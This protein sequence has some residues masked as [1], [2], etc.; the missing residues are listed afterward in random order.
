MTKRALWAATLALALATAPSAWAQFA[1]GNI[2][3]NVTDE[4]G[5]VLP[6]ATITMTGATIGARSTTAGSQ[7]DFRFL[8]LDPGS[9]KLSVA[10]TGFT[11]VNREVKVVTGTNVNLTFGLK[12]ATVEETVTVTAET[13]VVD[14]KKTGTS[15]TMSRD[16]LEKVPQAR[17]PWAVLRAVPGVLLDRVNIAGNESG[18]QAGFVAKGASDNNTIWNMDGVAITDMSAIGASPTYFDYDAFEEI[19]VS[20]GG[21]DI[22]AATGGISLN[23]VTK[24]GT[25]S[26]HGG[27]RYF[28]THD[29]LQSSNLPEELL[30]H[31]LPSGAA[32]NRLCDT[33]VVQGVCQGGT[34]RDKADHIQQVTDYGADLGGPIVKD[35]LWFYG[36]Y[37]VQDI[38]IQR[39]TGTRDKTLLKSYNGKLNWQAT[40]SDMIS[41]FYFNGKKIKIGRD[42]A[43]FGGVPASA[44]FLLNQG[45]E[46]PEG[47]LGYPGLG[48]LEWNHVFSPNFF[49]NAKYAYYGAGF[50]LFSVGDVSQPGT[51]DF[52]NRIATGSSYNYSTTRPQH[53]VNLDANYF[54]TAM[55]GNHELKFGFGYRKTP[56]DT[57]TEYGGDLWGLL[58]PPG[59][60]GLVN[61]FRDGVKSFESAYISGYV[62]DTFTKD[63][64]TV[65]LGLRFDHQTANNKAAV[66]PS[67]PFFP[68]A[69]PGID[70]DGSGVGVKWNDLSPRIGLTYALDDARKTVV[71]ASYA[72]YAGQL[73]TNF[74]TQDN[75]LL[76]SYLQYYWDDLNG[77]TFPQ[78][79]EVLVGAGV[80]YAYN[81]DPANP[82]SPS[83]P[84]VLDPDLK[85][86]HDSEIVVGIDRELFPN[87][88]VSAAYTYRKSSDLTWPAATPRNCGDRA[89]VLSDYVALDPVTQNTSLG[90]FTFQNFRAPAGTPGNTLTNRPDY[91]RQFSGIE[92]SM[93]KR[94]SN[95]WMGRVAFSYNDWTEHFKGGLTDANTS[96]PARTRTSPL[97]DGGQVSILSGGSGKAQLYSSVKWQVS[98]NA[99][100]QLP[101]NFEIA[102]A[103]FGRQGHPRP[104]FITARASG[105]PPKN[106]IPNGVS[107]DDMRY[108]NLWNVDFRLA[109][110]IKI[111]GATAVLSAEVFNAFNSGTELTR[112]LDAAS[113]S[114][115]RLDEILSPRIV[116]L[117]LRFTF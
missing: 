2:Y 96:D 107:V 40:S 93:I 67:N 57:L 47:G 66:V 5:A 41:L 80:Y 104:P 22:K 85:A 75:P 7:G 83:S 45:D 65:T 55:G 48:K 115:N 34:F 54:A 17:D 77:D 69:L 15:V 102:A 71:R 4:S 1:T 92:L 108:A 19:S 32:D 56:V 38:R 31:Q 14:T 68:N 105:E 39:L 37:G 98:A 33:R 8:N 46:K 74:G 89:C 30:S 12:V 25:N 58:L 9:Y 111:S 109:K 117:G 6:G 13:P 88:A 59:G 11:T 63:R 97:D 36:S 61:V 50:H 64:L 3:G 44:S 26:F 43:V 78:P 73:P 29:D 116:R 24:R 91:Y 81:V 76:P 84:N 51:V 110:N 52:I 18:Q 101:W 20:T 106:V 62:G 70:Y 35:K 99:M 49:L 100:Y 21:N 94:F 42:P 112:T 27:G 113:A 87:F 103:L 10:L 23:F 53:A 95:K 60:G 86:N 82:G 16:E 90:S 114:F 72:R 28:L 79:G